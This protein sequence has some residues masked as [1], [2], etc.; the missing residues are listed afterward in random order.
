MNQIMNYFVVADEVNR[1]TLYRIVQAS[2][3]KP[4]IVYVFEREHYID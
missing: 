2:E 4:L 3:T 1:F